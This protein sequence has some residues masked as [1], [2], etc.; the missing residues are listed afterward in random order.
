MWY[1]W[2]SRGET[3]KTGIYFEFAQSVKK[4]SSVAKIAMLSVITNAARDGNWQAAA[5]YLERT[6]PDNYGRRDRIKQEITG[7]NGGP[8]QVAKAPYLSKLTDEELTAY[9]RLCERL[10]D[11]D[12][13]LGESN[14]VEV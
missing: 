6:D 12:D 14:P 1:L 3:E 9:A 13:V 11:D 10:Q 2:L 5:W 8:I 7:K 4:A